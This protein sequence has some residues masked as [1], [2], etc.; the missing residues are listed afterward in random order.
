MPTLINSTYQSELTVLSPTFRRIDGLGSLH[1]E[2][3]K[4]QV[5]MSHTFTIYGESSF[6]I[7]MYLYLGSFDEDAPETNLIEQSIISEN[8]AKHQINHTLQADQQYLLLITTYDEGQT[9]EFKI[10]VT[11]SSNV[12][13]TRLSSI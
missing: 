4:L 9:G 7:I 8:V 11:G 12:D 2:L 5:N 3:V 1:Y 6:N 10:L 13:I